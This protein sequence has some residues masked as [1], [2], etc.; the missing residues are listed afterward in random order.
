MSKTLIEQLEAAED[1]D[2]LEALGKEHLGVNADKRKGIET[3]RAELLEL[4][5]AQAAGGDAAATEP[6]AENPVAPD[7]EPEQQAEPEAYRGRMLKHTKNGRLFPWTADLA[8]NRYL[9]EV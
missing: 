3:I 8:K 4:A 6:Q 1:K 2:T 7:P 9:K 5:E